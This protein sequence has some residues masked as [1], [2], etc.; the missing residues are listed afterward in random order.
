MTSRDD[1]TRTVAALIAELGLAARPSVLADR[2][3]LVL[4]L[5]PLP[6]VA[7]VAMATSASRVGLEFAGREVLVARFLDAAGCA[8]TRPAASVE[9][10]PYEREGLVISLW[11]REVLAGALDARLA[12]ARLAEC[13]RALAGLDRA[14]LPRWG[15][16]EEARAVLD[17]ALASPHLTEPERARVRGAWEIGEHVV[18]GA[19]AKSASMQAVHGDAHLGNVLASTRGPVWTDW[20]DAFVGPV[21]WDLASVRSRAELFGEDV[22][23]IEAACAGYA[24]PF[25]PELVKE[26]G[27][28]RNLQVI[29]WLAVFAERDVSLV[30][31]LRARVARLP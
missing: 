28:C 4:A 27:L 6:L 9:P 20:E 5:D 30:S 22:L 21:E 11:E 26:L 18:E 12:G 3:N 2:S 13:H 19:A 29:P 14:R 7:R 1:A 15:G 8:V 23:A 16:W 24:G 17:R 25:D 10:G 31:R